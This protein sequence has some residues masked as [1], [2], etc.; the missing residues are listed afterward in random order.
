[1]T[2][3]EVE[4]D[5]TCDLCGKVLSDGTPWILLNRWILG[6]GKNRRFAEWVDNDGNPCW[7]MENETASGS[8]LCLEPC[9]MTWIQGQMI[10]TD[11]A[12]RDG[13]PS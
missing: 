1:M 13:G 5:S 7:D 10:G 11:F 9:L 4:T 2:D 6:T 12:C 8:L 3:G